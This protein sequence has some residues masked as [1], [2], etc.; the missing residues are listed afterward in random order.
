MTRVAT[1]Y[2]WI[3]AL[4]LAFGLV[5]GIEDG[6]IAIVQ[7]LTPYFVLGCLLAIP[8]AAL[9]RSRSLGLALG[10]TGILFGLRFGDE[11]TSVGSDSGAATDLTVATW[12]IQ[13]GE[14]SGADT[15]AW[16]RPRPVDIVALQELT[17]DVAAAIEADGVLRDRY[18]YRV[19]EG[20]NSVSGAGLLSHFPIESAEY[21]TEPVHIEA[22]VRWPGGEI[23]VINAHPVHADLS[24][25]GGIPTGAD[26]A[27][28]NEELALLRAKVESLESA[29]VDVLLVGDF[30]TAPTEPAFTRLTS[31]LN[32]AH[33]AVGW[34]PGWTWRPG[35]F[36]FLGVGLLR[37]DLVLSTPGLQPI[38]TSIACPPVGDHCLLEAALAL[39]DR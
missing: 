24:L 3:A 9:V 19:L 37:I 1:A 8:I 31:G 26:P 27:S 2:T 20:R 29:G 28:R 17:P 18:P 7:I 32:D 16:L 39:R 10:V 21:S 6:P 34:G 30:N 14:N 38:E 35:R 23:A 13:A 5:S 4:L 15:V 25:V 33:A 12:N 36:V 22:R 11:W